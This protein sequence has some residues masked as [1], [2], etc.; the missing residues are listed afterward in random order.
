MGARDPLIDWAVAERPCTG[1]RVSGDVHVVAP[2]PHGVLLAVVDALGHGDDAAA[3]AQVAAETLRRHAAEP[4]PT[5]IDRCHR[6]LRS[7]RGAVLS[8]AA[9]DGRDETLTWAGVGNV[10]GF[11][12][13]A[14]PA[15]G[16]RH[17]E[18]LIPRS[19]VV[20]WNIPALRSAQ[21]GVASGDVLILA[22]DGIDNG[23]VEACDLGPPRQLADRILQRHAKPNDDALVLV[24]AYQGAR[25]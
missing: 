7:G 5:L 21:L 3:A 6:R 8:L 22:T 4:V 15:H 1:E 17:R 14:R 23:F 12:L 18:A 10:E 11:L 2:F 25:S 9:I 16:A 24:A 19:G 20:G 13:R